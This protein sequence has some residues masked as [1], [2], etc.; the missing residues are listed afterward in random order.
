M[1][2]D[3]FCGCGTTVH[4]AQKLGRWWIGIDVT[5]V[6]I[7]LIETRL[8]DAFG[9]EAEFAVHGVPRDLAGAQD[10]FDRDDR[11]K[12]EF[13]KW[14]CGLVKAYPQG[15]GKK[16]ADGGVDGL[17]RFGPEK[18]HTA[19]VSVKGGRRI[20]VAQVRELGDVV[21]ER[22]AAIG[23]FLTLHEPTSKMAEWA[24]GAGTFEVEGFEPVPRIQIVTVEEALERGPAAIHAPLRHA[25]VHKAARREA[26]DKQGSLDL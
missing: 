19:V 22:G 3:L 5:H 4:A 24:K 26:S 17:F 2:L 16:G 23:V 14:A 21:R 9:E 10:L 11:T 13:E 25:D 6:A 15:G 18:R 1:V 8:F 7:S 20:G 12:K